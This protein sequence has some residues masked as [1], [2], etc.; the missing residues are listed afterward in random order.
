MDATRP[1]DRESLARNLTLWTC[2][3]L[4][5][6]NDAFFAVIYPLLPLLA[7]ELH[8]SYA[9]VGLVKTSFSVA[10]SALQVPVGLLAERWAEYGLLVAGNAWVAAGLV[11][12]ALAGSYLPLLALTTLAGIGGNTQHPLAASLVSRH[13]PASRRA[14]A[15][16]TLNFAGDL[17]KMAGPPIVALVAIPFGW[18][19]ALIALGVFGLVYSALIARVPVGRRDVAPSTPDPD[20]GGKS[21]GIDSTVAEGAEQ[22]DA[23]GGWGIAQPRRFALLGLLGVIDNSTRGAALA[24][25]PFVLAE[26][27]LDPL[28]VS[29]LFTV[30]FVGGAAGKFGC[31]RLGDRFG[32]TALIVTTELITVAALALFPSAPLLVIPLLALAFGFV[33]NGTSSVL[34]A[35]VADLVSEARRARGYGLYY[36]LVNAS[37]AVAPVLYGLF[38]DRAGLG[39]VF[40][41]MAAINS[42]TV[43]LAFAIRGPHA[44]RPG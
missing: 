9:E 23:G 25:L 13:A 1:A 42:T 30:V 41:A 36:T 15:V 20:A 17:G 19:T 40:W 39:P 37:S 3:S 32:P 44:M 24:F 43:L 11:G 18:R 33:L 2:S 14:T 4:H 16:G 35:T 10:S 28:Q 38:G 34:Y 7:A 27:G 8:L 31:G 21:P 29:W 12:M 26:K 22:A 5:T 6:V